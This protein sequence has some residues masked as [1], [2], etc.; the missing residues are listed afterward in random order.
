MQGP[1]S[2]PLQW[3]PVSSITFYKANY[4]IQMYHKDK[5]V[6]CVYHMCMSKIGD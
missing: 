6:Y 2:V 5:Y 3:S 1:G 4:A